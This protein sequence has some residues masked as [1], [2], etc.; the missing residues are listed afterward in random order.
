MVTMDPDSHPR[1]EDSTP[2]LCV[3]TVKRP[4]KGKDPFATNLTSTSGSVTLT[5]R[6]IDASFFSCLCC[7]YV[8]VDSPLEEAMF[9]RSVNHNSSSTTLEKPDRSDSIFVPY[10]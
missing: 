6:F 10:S 1:T 2:I 5:N 9:L 3:Q 7:S 4:S 8:D